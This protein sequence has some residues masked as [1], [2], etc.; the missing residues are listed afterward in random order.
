MLVCG[1]CVCIVVMPG[2]GTGAHQASPSSCDLLRP[3]LLC[4]RSF[5]CYQSS[6]FGR[7]LDQALGVNWNPPSA[8]RNVAYLSRDGVFCC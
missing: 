4:L 6:F 7:H 5:F 2:P 8:K 3:G 1:E